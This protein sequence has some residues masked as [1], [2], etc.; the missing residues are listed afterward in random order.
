MNRTATDNVILEMLNNFES[1]KNDALI[2]LLDLK[3]I[4]ETKERLE[5]ANLRFEMFKDA[6]KPKEDKGKYLTI[7][8]CELRIT[9]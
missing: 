6:L 3:S 9:G 4:P 8:Y 7:Q 2:A 5:A 1:I